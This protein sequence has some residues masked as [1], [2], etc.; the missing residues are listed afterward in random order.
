MTKYCIIGNSA[1]AVGAVEAI[2]ENDEEGQITIISKEPYHVYS[3]PLISYL[4]AGKIG[5][6]DMYYRDSHFYRDNDVEFINSTV[7]TIDTGDRSVTMD[8]GK[9][10]YDKLL[11]AT[12][13]TPFVPPTDGF[14]KEGVFT[15]TTW[16]DAKEISARLSD[17]KKAV[18]IGGGMIGIKSSEALQAR[19]IEV[20]IVEL[21]DSILSTVFDNIASTI[22]KEH[23]EMRGIRILTGNS[24]S[25]IEGKGSVSGVTLSDGENIDC[26]LVIFAIGVRPNVDVAKDTAIEINRGIVV[27]EEMQTSAQGVFAAGDVAEAYDR[28][29]GEKRPLPIWPLAYRQGKI[30]GSNM[31]GVKREYDGGFVMN[32]IELIDV[33]TI[34]FGLTNTDEG[35]EVIS[36]QEGEEYKKIVLKNDRIVG[37]IFI[38]CIDRAGILSGLIR[39]EVDVSTFKEEL[40]SDNFGYISFPKELR[41]ERLMG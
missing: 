15:F 10:E 19:G 6:E 28:L 2:R 16:D 35:L 22:A 33:P 24:V 8:D 17:V 38:G 30:A 12:G 18:V 40:L 7:H 5:D 32:S 39:D 36:K 20:T 29:A 37:A 34:S 9:I 21:A 26:D 13:G 14:E 11:I 41:V 23:L 3:R 25:K 1:A 4:L 31:S 27:D